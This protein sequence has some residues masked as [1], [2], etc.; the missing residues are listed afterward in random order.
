M[1][2]ILFAWEFGENWGHLSRDLP[3]ARRLRAAG[4]QVLCAVCDTRMALE[5]LGPAGI[6]FVQVP[7]ARRVARTTKPIANHAEMLITSGYGERDTLRGLVD[8]WRG[9]FDLFRPDVVVGD[10]APTALLAARTRGVPTVLTGSGFELPPALS[11]LP[12]FKL[13]VEIP[14][15]RLLLAETVALRTINSVLAS[16]RVQLLARFADLFDA[17]CK[18]LTTFSELDHFGHRDGQIY[19]GPIF[20]LPQ[21]HPAK[22]RIEA[23]GPRIFAY[24]RPWT[25]HVELL[26][27]ALSE[28]EAEVICAFPGVDAK[29]KQRFHSPRLQLFPMAV[30]IENLLPAADLVIG[31]GSGTIATTLLSGVPL[32]MVPLM[33]EQYL[34]AL[35]VGA[36]GAGMTVRGKSSQQIFSSAIAT[37]LSESRYREAA[38]GFAK[39]YRDFDSG[40]AADFV[41]A[42]IQD[43]LGQ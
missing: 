29:L 35:R 14:K 33:Y 26:L 3:I 42:T 21:A 38:T 22:W 25:P 31:Y 41:A 32:L 2:N 23:D 12:A 39:K 43:V 36:L 9:L 4:H 20:E 10:Y 18:I 6:P 7:V 24:L 28:I 11:P 40:R 37:L 19:S 34:G 16:Y 8:G 30:S 17:E 15:E 13:D 5:V 1:S 27:R